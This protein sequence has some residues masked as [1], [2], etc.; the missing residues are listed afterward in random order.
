MKTLKKQSAATTSLPEPDER[1]SLSVLAPDTVTEKEEEDSYADAS[2]STSQRRQLHGAISTKLIATLVLF[3]GSG[4]CGLILA[5]GITAAK[6]DQEQQFKILATETV[7]QVELVWN[8]YELATLWI[9][10]ATR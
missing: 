5:F 8:R 10:Q 3:I 2:S 1:V 9:H 4:A 6:G 7:R